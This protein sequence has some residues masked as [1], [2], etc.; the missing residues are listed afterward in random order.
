MRIIFLIVAF[1]ISFVAN[2]EVVIDERD[3]LGT[4]EP[5]NSSSFTIF[6]YNAYSLTFYS[7][8]CYIAT[9][10]NSGE[11]MKCKGW[12]IS[13]ND[14]L[15]IVTVDNYITYNL[16]YT[17]AKYVIDAFVKDEYIILKDYSGYQS[18]R[19]NKVKGSGISML[20]ID[21][22]DDDDTKYTLQGIATNNPD[23]IY[24]QNGKAK[25]GGH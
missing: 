8:S 21:E 19:L 7:S 11:V 16:M 18:I 12:F 23:G 15:N 4:W 20:Y 25:L 6:G 22:N 2:A 10:P 17:V 9:S 24:I 14:K 1:L 3:L 13:N 5:A